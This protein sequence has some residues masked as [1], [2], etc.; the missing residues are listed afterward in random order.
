MQ[1]GLVDETVCMLGCMIA[2]NPFVAWNSVGIRQFLTITD[3][4][5]INVASNGLSHVHAAAELAHCHTGLSS[6][7]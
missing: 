3:N 6:C 2:G 4:E 1:A 7:R 5:F